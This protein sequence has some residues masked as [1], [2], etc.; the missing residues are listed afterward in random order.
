MQFKEEKKTYVEKTN[1]NN[2]LRNANVY[3]PRRYRYVITADSTAVLRRAF[4]MFTRLSS[5][6]VANT[7]AVRRQW[8]Y[9][10]AIPT[11]TYQDYVWLQ[12]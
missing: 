9:F 10:E 11:R 12:A 5:P 7:C 1:I 2:E 4:Q 3:R 6:P 8:P